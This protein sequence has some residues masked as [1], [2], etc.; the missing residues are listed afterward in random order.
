MKK[1]PAFQF[2]PKDWLT[3]PTV[4]KMSLRD[5]GL[6]IRT[7]SASWLSDEP[8]TLPLPMGV[9]AR[10]VGISLR[11]LCD[12]TAK[13]KTIWIQRDSK[14]FNDKLHNQWLEL[15]ERL[16]HQSVAGKIG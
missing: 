2:Y 5:Q 7:L 3:S 10:L 14:L 1:P 13:W 8:G 6:F 9:A 16:K 15:Q 4:N 12:F 11:N